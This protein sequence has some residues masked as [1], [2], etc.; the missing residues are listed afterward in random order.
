MPKKLTFYPLD[1][2]YK[3]IDGKTAILLFGRSTTGDQVIVLDNTFNP[4]FYAVLKEGSDADDFIERVKK[5]KV[6]G[7]TY[8]SFVTDAKTA[9]K[10]L[11]GKNV[12][13]VKIFCNLP[14]SVPVIRNEI[15]EW[16]AIQE[17]YEFDIPFIRR[18]L[19]DKSITPL[20]TCI[21]EGDFIDFHARAP[22]FKATDI[23][24]HNTDS[25]EKPKIL[26][27]D[28]E[29][30]NPH[31]KSLNPEKD[32][33]I[34][35]SFHGERYKKVL[36]WKRF[37][38]PEDYVEF[39]DGEQQ[40]LERFKEII[41]K[42][43]PDVLCGYYSD[44][45]D[46][47]Y[48]KARCDHYK[49]K[50][51]LGLDYSEIS[52]KKGMNPAAIVNGIVHLDV[53]SFVRRIVSRRL[54]TYIYTLDLVA[55]E[56]IGEKKIDVDMDKL[57]EVWDKHPEKLKEYTKYNL[58]DSY[59]TYSLCKKLW[60][61]IEELVRITGVPLFDS[62]RMGFS[63]LVEWFILKQTPEFN[64]IALN[65]PHH[66]DIEKRRKQTYTGAFVIEPKPGLYKDVVVF[67]FRSLYPSIIVSHNIGLSTLNCE[68]CTDTEKAPT[69]KG[70]YWFC[71]K[72]KGF[73]PSLLEDLISRRARIKQIMKKE[74]NV[75]LEARSEALKVLANS[76]YGYFGFFGARY[77]SIECARSITAY[78]R[79]YINKTVEYAKKEGFKVLYGDTDSVF[80]TLDGKKKKDAEE[81]LEKIN[82]ELPGVMELELEGFYPSGIFVSAKIGAFGAKKRYA[83]LDQ[84]DNIKIV[85]FETVRRNVS[86]IAK[87]T[88]EEVLK[89]I[90]REHDEEKALKYVKK[91][92]NNIKEKKVKNEDVVIKTQLTK[93]IS[94][95]AAVGPHVAVAQRMKSKGMNVMAGTIISYIVAGGKGIIRDRAKF[96]EEVKEGG[97]DPEYYINHQIIPSVEKIFEVLGYKKEDLLSA[98]TQK[99]LESFFG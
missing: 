37:K 7:K 71:I 38:A 57:F 11:L 20:E 42:E 29:T 24:Q 31:G 18:Y 92:I 32:P 50:L 22:V 73:L 15:K 14:K 97:Y 10:K 61:N 68:C 52:F 78:G 1:I 63:Q 83:L 12:I 55:E 81:F 8:D 59:L 62:V 40:L 23:K 4:Y 41:E 95:Y 80:I 30:Y 13:A 47:P 48:I 87:N 70:E 76:F 82:S 72:K 75:L 77:Y 9:K 44:G 65:N 84:Q 91:I 53:L 2:T 94:E 86:D 79:F 39:V 89:I 93:D 3:A 49:I 98:K 16:R 88:Q 43:K 5:V 26:A 19:I 66:D 21:A 46:F 17:C 74:K 25:I 45:F 35:L 54:Q 60:P 90:L 67:D 69:E 96:P 64:E 58:H 34:M 51:D 36:T 56:L 27:F 28:I 6:E 33:V 99:K 85:G